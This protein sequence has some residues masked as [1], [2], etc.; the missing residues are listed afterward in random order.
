MLIANVSQ[1]LPRIQSFMLSSCFVIHPSN[2]LC[3]VR[4]HFQAWV[5]LSVNK[6]IG[7][8]FEQ[9]SLSESSGLS[10]R[11]AVFLP[12]THEGEEVQPTLD[13]AFPAFHF[14]C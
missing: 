3:P 14:V 2:W 10:L 7:E 5:M 9:S 8:S 12:I 6:L 1:D 4:S 11:Q 13:D